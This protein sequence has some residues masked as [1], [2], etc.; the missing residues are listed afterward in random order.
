[1]IWSTKAEVALPDL[2]VSIS[3]LRTWTVFCILVSAARSASSIILSP[4]KK[5]RCQYVREPLPSLCCQPR[6]DRKPL[7]AGCSPCTARRQWHPLREDL[8]SV[9]RGDP[10]APA[11][12]PKDP[13]WDRRYTRRQPCSWPSGAP[14]PL[15]RSHAGQPPYLWSCMD[16]LF[17]PRRSLL[18][19]SPDGGWP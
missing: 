12:W 2:M 11:S 17:Q 8:F 7:W 9:P 19:P 13:Y 14:R 15:S 1:M 4:P 10:G 16:S 18:C 6:G 5:P 3:L